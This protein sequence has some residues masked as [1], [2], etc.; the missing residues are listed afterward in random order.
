M[1]LACLSLFALTAALFSPACSGQYV[2]SNA[3]PGQQ[4]SGIIECDDYLACDVNT[5]CET[6]ECIQVPGCSSA[7]CVSSAVLCDEA[8]GVQGCAVATSYP[9]QLSSCPDG[10]PIKGK[11]H[12]QDQP[13]SV[14][15]GGGPS[16][17]GM[18][19]VAGSYA[20][21]GYPSGGY[22]NAP[23]YAGEGGTGYGNGVVD[24]QA[25]ARCNADVPCAAANFDCVSIPGCQ[26]AVCAPVFPLCSSVCAGE[27]AVLES[28]PL[29][30]SCST[31][32]IVGYERYDMGT[33][34][35]YGYGGSPYGYAG[36]PASAGYGG[37]P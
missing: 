28:Y 26:M 7:V 13:P 6:G 2:G 20:I 19:A 27:C 36:E 33:G 9:A 15:T 21:G 4:R 37:Q 5:A 18:P 8:C 32:P 24:C 22:G 17:A 11:G 31:G 30:L 25:Y 35:A 23:G 10:T 29:Q 1:R 3:D 12:G 34:G 14:G 16:Y